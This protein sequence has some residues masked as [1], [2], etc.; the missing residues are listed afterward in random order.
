MN[1]KI[2]FSKEEYN[3]AKFLVLNIIKEMKK[4]H[5]KLITFDSNI[6]HFIASDITKKQNL[7][8]TKGWFKNGPYIPVI[9]DILVDLEYMDKSQ[10]QLYGNEKIMEKG[11]ICNCHK[12][13]K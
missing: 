2:K 11:I 4:H 12:E 7:Y 3:T 5:P 9:D 10:H 1:K 13:V 6:I 8:L